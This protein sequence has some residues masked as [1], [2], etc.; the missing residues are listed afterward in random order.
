[1]EF[2]RKKLSIDE[3]E[4][5]LLS[6]PIESVS[7]YALMIAPVYVPLRANGKF[8]AIKG[9]LDF[10]SPEELA[11]FRTFESLFFHESVEDAL[12]F[13]EVGREL[14]ALLRWTPPITATKDRIVLE[15]APFEISDAVLKITGPLLGPD[16]TIEP[17]YVT[18]LVNEVCDLLP[19]SLL[20]AS[21]EKDVKQHELALFRSSLV[22]L[23]ALILGKNELSFLNSLRIETLELEIGERVEIPGSDE[24]RELQQLAR[25][26]I[27]NGDCDQ[28]TIP[29]ADALTHLRAERKLLRRL[30]RVRNEMAP[31]APQAP[32]LRGPRGFLSV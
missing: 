4:T 14:R 19:G 28:I 7:P 10:F 5:R 1:M 6:C 23:L 3:G 22:V 30:G 25:Q 16:M 27:P 26:W 2:V 32:S 11:R 12:R 31:D 21:R 24:I 17:F 9:P 8:V 13:R 18:V 29:E 15:P 20:H